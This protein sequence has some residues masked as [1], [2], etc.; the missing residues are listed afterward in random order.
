MTVDVRADLLERSHLKDAALYLASYEN[1]LSSSVTAGEN[2]GRTLRHDYV[3]LQ[4]EGP[5]DLG[6][7]GRRAERR[8]VP[9]LPGAVPENSG[10]VAFVQN[11]RSLE[12]LQALMLPYCPAAGLPG[13]G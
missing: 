10:A 7:D 9:L 1:R 13:K 3:V 4:W 6:P 5:L 8:Q 12:V 2:R 11:R